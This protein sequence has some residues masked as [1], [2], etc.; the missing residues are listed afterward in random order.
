MSIHHNRGDECVFGILTPVISSLITRTLAC[1]FLLRVVVFLFSPSPNAGFSGRNEGVQFRSV[2]NHHDMCTISVPTRIV[3]V[4]RS[5]GVADIFIPE[6]CPSFSFHA[7]AVLYNAVPYFSAK[8]KLVTMR[9]LYLKNLLHCSNYAFIIPL[10]N[11][12]SSSA[13]SCT[14]PNIS[15]SLVSSGGKPG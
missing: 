1:R 12:K 2:M 9:H 8:N 13:S 15:L 10:K 4:G 6:L 14:W 7:N 3:R 5:T 11:E